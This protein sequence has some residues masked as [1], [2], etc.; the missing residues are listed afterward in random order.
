M[1]MKMKAPCSVAW[2]FDHKSRHHQPIKIVFDGN[3][4]SI[5]KI[6]NHYQFR[7]GRTLFHVYGV[8][9]KTIFLK[10]VLNTD[11]LAWEL[12]EIGDHDTN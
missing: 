10:I 2:Y 3:A 7:E 5:V 6:G 12:W 4:Y 11:T 1:I 8:V 9:S